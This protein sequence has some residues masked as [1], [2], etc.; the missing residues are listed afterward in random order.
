MALSSREMEVLAMAWHC[1]DQEPKVDFQKLANLAGYKTKESAGVTFRNVMKKIKNSVPTPSG[2]TASVPAT[3]KKP[4]TPTTKTPNTNGAGSSNKRNTSKAFSN[5]LAD[6]P[7]KS[8][9][10]STTATARA[11]EEGSG[12]DFALSE[13]EEELK[14]KRQL[15]REVLDAGRDNGSFM[16]ELESQHGSDI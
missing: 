11:D 3:P 8:Q 6:T 2:G 1:M 12:T 4:K 14:I 7:S 10:R 5:N 9:K 16:K 13:G 15:K